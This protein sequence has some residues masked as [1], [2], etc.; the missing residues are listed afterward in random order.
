MV[1]MVAIFLRCT[2]LLL[3]LSIKEVSSCQA[4]AAVLKRKEVCFVG[5][6]GGL[7]K[8]EGC[9]LELVPKRSI[10]DKAIPSKGLLRGNM[11]LLSLGKLTLENSSTT[12]FRLLEFLCFL[13]L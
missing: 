7:M 8:L 3:E 6:G 2:E 12:H 5:F 10:Q 11:L 1:V 9:Q 4:R 13:W